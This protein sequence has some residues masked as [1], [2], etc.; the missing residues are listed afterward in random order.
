MKS[1]FLHAAF[2][3]LFLFFT[4][5]QGVLAQTY[6][7]EVG[8][9]D[10]QVYIHDD[11]TATIDYTI[12]FKND[13]GADPIDYVDIGAPNSSYSLSNVSAWIGDKELTDIQSS[14]YVNNGVAIG[15][16]E[17][18]IQ[19]G[20]QG[21]VQVRIDGVRDMLFPATGE[22]K[23]Y[24]SFQFEPNFFDSQFVNGNTNLTV[25]LILPPGIQTEQPRF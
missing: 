2:L 16:G 22:D 15:L 7:F 25:T 11:G 5:F 12:V 21:T 23:D 20:E 3:L 13:P 19:P 8:Q 24:A 9:E 14:P 1:K 17:N 6:Q 18:A 4:N 10:I